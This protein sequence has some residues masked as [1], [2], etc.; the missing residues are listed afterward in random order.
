MLTTFH[1]KR[2]IEERVEYALTIADDAEK[3][4]AAWI[5]ENP[6]MALLYARAAHLKYSHGNCG[7]E[8]E[9]IENTSK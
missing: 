9:K 8:F 2:T 1:S 6:H 3:A 5:R 7:C 4:A